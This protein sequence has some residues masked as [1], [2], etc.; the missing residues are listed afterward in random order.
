MGITR[1]C[2]D[3]KSFNVYCRSSFEFSARL[4]FKFAFDLRFVC[5]SMK[6]LQGL[7]ASQH[8]SVH[9]HASRWPNEMQ[10]ERKFKTCIILHLPLTRVLFLIMQ[11]CIRDSCWRSSNSEN[12]RPF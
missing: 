9:F 4:T 8:T 11:Y 12:L 7:V 10:F 1:V 3:T 2:S 5:F 6:N